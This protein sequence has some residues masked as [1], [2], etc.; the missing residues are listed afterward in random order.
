MDYLFK[1]HGGGGVGIFSSPQS[2]FA[3]HRWI[4]KNTEN[5]CLFNK[6]AQRRNKGCFFK[7][8]AAVLAAKQKYGGVPARSVSRQRHFTSTNF[9]L[10][11]ARPQKAD[12]RSSV[13]CGISTQLPSEPSS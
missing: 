3:Q 1:K 8:I 10:K 6:A 11:Q 9:Q 12:P 2:T 13:A 4:L 7:L 5:P